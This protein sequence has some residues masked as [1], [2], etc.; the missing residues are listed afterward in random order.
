MSVSVQTLLIALWGL[1][2]DRRLS[3]PRDVRSLL[4]YT[5]SIDGAWAP[6][7][8]DPVLRGVEDTGLAGNKKPNLLH[9]NKWGAIGQPFKNTSSWLRC[10]LQT[11]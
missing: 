7:T 2:V 10:M 6:W 5:L 4:K 8:L 11:K 3:L 1:T 9:A